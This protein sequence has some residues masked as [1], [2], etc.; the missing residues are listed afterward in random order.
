[1]QENSWHNKLFHLNLEKVER[2]KITK[3]W[4][5]QELFTWNQMQFF[6]VF[7]GLSYGE[8]IKNST[9]IAKTSFKGTLTQI[10]KSANISF[11]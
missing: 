4:I 9:E 8:K 7:E 2:E 5:S 1:M 3:M 11:S 6:V 10:W